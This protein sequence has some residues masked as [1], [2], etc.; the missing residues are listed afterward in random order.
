VKR[1]AERWG[2]A[3]SDIA[4]RGYR[5]MSKPCHQEE[6]A[7]KVTPARHGVSTRIVS[8]SGVSKV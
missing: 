8:R 7:A 6:P 5:E 2:A 3:E 4:R 1:R